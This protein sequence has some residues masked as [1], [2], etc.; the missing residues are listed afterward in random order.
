MVSILLT[1]FLAAAGKRTLAID[2]DPQASLTA[3]FSRVDGFDPGQGQ[4]AYGIMNG[5]V[6]DRS[7]I[8]DIRENL[9][10]IASSP[11]LSA[12]ETTAT[13][14]ALQGYLSGFQ[15]EFDCCIIDTAG[16]WS[17]LVQAAFQSSAMVVIPTLLPT[18]DLENALWSYGRV[19]AYPGLEGRILLNQWK[20]VRQDEESIELFESDIDG[21][22][23]ENRI[24]Q[25]SV[26]RRYTDTQERISAGVKSKQG[27]FESVQGIAGEIFGEVFDVESF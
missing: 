14:V 15:D 18:D 22:L 27:L 8:K 13:T 11:S 23:L 21:K 6:Y 16:N 5:E 25:S 19:K 9:S 3:Y 7:A 24:P 20:G 12:I 10:I 26:I 2:L 4:G 17:T 1:S